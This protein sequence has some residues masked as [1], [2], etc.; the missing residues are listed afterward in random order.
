MP[1]AL[2]GLFVFISLSCD[3]QPTSSSKNPF[4]Q[5][6]ASALQFSALAG[7]ENPPQQKIAVRNLGEGDLDFSIIESIPWVLADRSFGLPVDTIFITV[8]S[9]SLS[10]GEHIDTVLVNSTNATNGTQRIQ[11]TVQ[12][13]AGIQTNAASFAFNVLANE[14]TP[15]PQQLLINSAGI[16]SIAVRLLEEIPWLS[17]SIDTGTTPLT[18]D[19][20]PNVSSLSGGQYLDTL[21]ITSLDAI[22]S[23]LSIV[24]SLGVSSWQLTE[25]N[26]AYDIGAIEFVSPSVGFAVG[27]L[28]SQS[29]EGFILRTSDGGENWGRID[30]GTFEPLQGIEFTNSQ[31]GWVV[32]DSS[33]LLSTTNGGLTWVATPRSSLPIDSTV[34]LWTITFWDNQR[35]WICGTRGTIL[36][37]SNAGLTWTKQDS[38]SPLSLSDIDFVS[39][40]VGWLIG[41]GGYILR[42]LDGG[43]SWVAQSS[44]TALDLWGVSMIDEL[45]GWVVGEGGTLLRT[46]DAG[47][48]WEPV[49][50][51]STSRIQDIYFASALRGW[52]IGAEGMILFTND[53]GQNWSRQL[54][55]TDELLFDLL[56]IDNQRGWIV[57][58]NGVTLRTLSGGF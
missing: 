40:T 32:G 45:N 43:S 4:I 1:F 16:D 35:G 26:S 42:T 8:I 48:T 49:S 31:T 17:L 20:L 7:G 3:S 57:G 39:P 27:F 19:L 34:N 30:N 52:L 15:T 9:N 5:L 18:V 46:S 29:Q 55:G 51:G 21:L 22:N 23:P 6:S 2:L 53:G 36:H 28:G 50:I 56:F 38:P 37:T 25:L 47:V 13:G 14:T 33:Q 24:C 58:Q 41:N 54:S 10:A 12:V 44:G 11:I